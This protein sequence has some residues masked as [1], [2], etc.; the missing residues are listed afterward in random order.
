MQR[1][2]AISLVCLCAISTAAPAADAYHAPR[3]GLGQPDLQG[4]WSNATITPTSRVATFGTRA[5]YTQEEAAAL[6]GAQ[7]AATD[8][9][10]APT[11]DNTKP[12]TGGVIVARGGIGI[13]GNYNRG[14][15]DPGSKVMRVHDEPRNSL[16][17]TPN[18]QTPPFKPGA[19][20]QRPPLAAPVAGA[21]RYDNPE[22]LGLGDRCLVSFGR[23]GGPPM[24]PNGF[25]N[26]NYQVVQ[27][28]DAV[29]IDIEMVHDT[30]I[31]R[32]NGV[33]RT[34]GVRPW[35]GD[36]IGHFEGDTLVVETTNIPQRQAYSGAW[37]HLTITEKFTR[38]AKDRL[39]YQFIVNDPTLW[40]KPWGGEYEFA[41]L[42]GRVMEYACH[43][44]NYALEGILAGARQDEA[45]AAQKAQKPVAAK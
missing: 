31:I 9:G 11:A 13:D 10:N 28:T 26:N 25:Y 23:N 17:T 4:Q 19:G 39:L 41:S 6:E 43:E 8:K 15:F 16:L 40:D 45:Q 35:F 30:R 7:Q 33:H 20:P 36:S 12:I 37:E 14:W 38:V 34:D 5:A 32:L 1:E 27:S 22:Q 2:L 3:N 18:G 29:A 42:N 21:G 44:G 24:F